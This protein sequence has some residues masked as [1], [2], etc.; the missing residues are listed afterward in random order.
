[1]MFDCVIQT[2]TACPFRRLI[3]IELNEAFVATQNWVGETHVQIHVGSIQF[4]LQASCHP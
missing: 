1:M 2:I 4:V 3:G